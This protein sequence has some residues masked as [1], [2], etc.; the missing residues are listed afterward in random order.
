MKAL[1]LAAGYGKRLQPLTNVIPKSMVE[2]NGTP[3]LVNALDNLIEVGIKEIGIVVG[4]M[5]DYIK[6]KIG[7][8]YK[9]AVIT[10]Y[11]NSRYLETNNVVSLYIAKDFCNDDM[12]MLECDIYYNKDIIEQLMRGKGEC[13]ILVSPFNRETMDGTVIRVEEDKAIELILGSW[14]KSDFEYADVRKT[15]NMYR[16]T[17]EFVLKYIPLVS[18]YVKVMGEHSY[19]EKVLG[20]LLYLKECDIRVVEVPE[21]AWCEIDDADDLARAREVFEK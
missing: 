16:F 15:V 13:S 17:K 18:W 7:N 11:E 10:Y 2:V 8:V 4:H 5:A 3:L 19:Y 6:D 21:N 9:G 12:L 14:Q 20:S 1:I